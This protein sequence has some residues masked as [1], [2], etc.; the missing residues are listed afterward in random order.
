MSR[1]RF[2]KLRVSDAELAD[3]RAKALEA[4]MTVSDFMRF[5]VM[6]FRLRRTGADR[7]RL[8]QLARI[9][10]N[11]NQLVRWA[12]THKAAGP[13]LEVVLWLNRLTIEVMTVANAG[14]DDHAD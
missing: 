6:N 12:N 2:L 13:A 14:G 9:G 7:E 4:G 5:R 1:G 11:V 3:I 8:R 10:S